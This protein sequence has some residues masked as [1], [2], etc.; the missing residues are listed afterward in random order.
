MAAVKVG[1]NGFGRIGRI[2]FRALAARPD[3]FE[4]VAINDLGDPQ[5]LAWLLKYDSVQ[6]RFP[7]TV[8]AEVVYAGYGITAPE[9]GYDDFKDIDVKGKIVL[10][11]PR[12]GRVEPRIPFTMHTD[13]KHHRQRTPV[14]QPSVPTSWR[15]G[16]RGQLAHGRWRSSV[17]P[18][19]TDGDHEI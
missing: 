17:D 2:T 1:I 9:L 5:K 15:E 18:S 19:H 16:L 10:F 6:G 13:P 14:P 3:E 12:V 8:E 7:G 4:V 11:C